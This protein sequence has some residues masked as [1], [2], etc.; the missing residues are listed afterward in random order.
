MP[1]DGKERGDSMKHTS[2]IY[3]VIS[4]VIMLFYISLIILVSTILGV[5]DRSSFL[6][7]TI[8]IAP[9][10]VI[11]PILIDRKLDARSRQSFFKKLAI[12]SI[13][14]ILL[15]MSFMSIANNLGWTNPNTE[16][17]MILVFW[18]GIVSWIL[19]AIITITVF[20]IGIG[21]HK[22]LKGKEEKT[23]DLVHPIM[24]N[25]LLSP[26]YIGLVLWS[27]ASII[28]TLQEVIR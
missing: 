18:F 12:L 24:F 16:G 20:L 13:I 26:F 19:S 2:K 25:S 23:F 4:I 14:L 21:I 8:S 17:W 10:I 28:A 7:L 1:K 9:T 6:I 27:F 5:A 11:M 3:I 22:K 15:A